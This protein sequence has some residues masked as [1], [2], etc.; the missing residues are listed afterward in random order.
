[1]E[2]KGCHRIDAPPAMVWAGLADPVLLQACLPGCR[3]MEK[4]GPGAFEA[5]IAVKLGPLAAIFQGQLHLTA[6]EPPLRCAL[7]GEGQGGA[8]GSTKGVAQ[9]NLTPQEGGTELAYAVR[10]QFAGKLAEI[11]EADVEEAARQLAGQFLARFAGALAQPQAGSPAPV[12]QASASAKRAG[13]GR[14]IGQHMSP[15]IWTTGLVA[16]SLILILLFSV[17]MQ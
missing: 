16:V 5:A 12:R 7:A 2:L 8:A 17:V 10:V 9:V 11:G 13:D 15:A 3:Q 1:M 14:A 6:Q 4:T